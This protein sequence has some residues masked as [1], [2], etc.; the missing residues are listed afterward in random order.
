MPIAPRYRDRTAP[1]GRVARYWL[2][3]AG[4]PPRRR[5]PLGHV[6]RQRHR[7]VPARLHVHRARRAADRRAVAALVAHDRLPRR[8]HDVLDALVRVVPAA[9]GRRRRPRAREHARQP[10]RRAARA[11]TPASR[12]GRVRC[13]RGRPPSAPARPRPRSARVERRPRPVPDVAAPAPSLRSDRISTRRASTLAARRSSCRRDGRRGLVTV[14]VQVIPTVAPRLQAPRARSPAGRTAAGLELLADA[15]E[16]HRERRAREAIATAM[17]PFAEPSSFVSATPVT[18]TASR[19]AAPA[20]RRSGRSSRRA[21]A[22]SR[23]ARPS[24]RWAITRRTFSSS[25]MRFVCVCRRPA[26]STSTT[27][28]PRERA[29]VDRVVGDRGGIGAALGA[30]ELGA[31]PLRPD[32]ELLVGGGAERVGGGDARPSGRAR[33][34]GTRAC[35]S[36]SSCRCR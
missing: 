20:G 31:G 23:A 9:R 11:S 5:L 13:A 12:S 32:L 29:S 30:D 24:S 14:S 1:R 15:D 8:L 25:A 10:R 21:R 26:V 22:A 16:L 36:S 35:R 3:G 6:R 17:P 18:S 34:G 33:A 2:D 28:R 19:T 27:S 4:Q 7:L